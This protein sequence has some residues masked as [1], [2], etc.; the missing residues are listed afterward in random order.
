VG[1]ARWMQAPRAELL[2]RW[3]RDEPLTLRM[4]VHALRPRGLA[5]PPMTVD[6]NGQRLDP[7]RVRPTDA[8]PAVYELRLPPSALEERNVLAFEWPGTLASFRE[9]PGL[10]VE[11]VEW[12]R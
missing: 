4:K 7:F 10:R 6:L 3:N 9:L 5:G 8:L 11:S 12:D 1:G 2:F